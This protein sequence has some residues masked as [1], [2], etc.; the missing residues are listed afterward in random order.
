MRHLPMIGALP[1][2]PQTTPYLLVK[3]DNDGDT[4]IITD[5]EPGWIGETASRAHVTTREIGA[6]EPRDYPDETPS[7]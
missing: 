1:T 7:F 6:W 5:A 2:R 4:F 3:Q